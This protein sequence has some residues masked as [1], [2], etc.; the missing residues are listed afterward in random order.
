MILGASSGKFGWTEPREQLRNM[1][2]TLFTLLSVAFLAGCGKQAKPESTS[3]GPAVH[4]SFAVL[5]TALR[6][7]DGAGAASRVTPQTLELYERCRK[8]ALDSTG[9][10]FE[11]LNE[12]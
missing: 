1:K 2:R 7:G 5:K 3:A 8:L 9:T 6:E 12:D 10:D 11:S 4:Q